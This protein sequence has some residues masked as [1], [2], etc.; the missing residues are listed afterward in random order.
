MNIRA[1]KAKEALKKEVKEACRQL[2]I[3][4]R[5]SSTRPRKRQKTQKEHK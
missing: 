2:E 5:A 4:S 1:R 3:A